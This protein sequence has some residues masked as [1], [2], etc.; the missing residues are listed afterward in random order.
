MRVCARGSTVGG[1]STRLH[2]G[3]WR[4]KESR[5]WL[6]NSSVNLLSIW[7]IWLNLY[8]D[9]ETSYKISAGSS[10][11]Q[12][13]SQTWKHKQ[14]IRLHFTF[15]TNTK[16]NSHITSGLCSNQLLESIQKYLIKLCVCLLQL[17]LALILLRSTY[18]ETEAQK[19]LTCVGIPPGSNT[20]KYLCCAW[21][22][23][24]GISLSSQYVSFFIG[25]TKKFKFE[26]F[27][28][29]SIKDNCHVWW[30]MNGEK[31]SS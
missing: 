31:V 25:I 6:D 28:G 21:F 16:T 26:A 24:P 10:I 3:D 30:E 22:G 2:P 12:I 20:F 23:L 4:C 1:S 27:C 19:T 5:L 11:L 14:Y 7:F 15:K 9:K 17:P 13:K 29:Q 18:L 8:W